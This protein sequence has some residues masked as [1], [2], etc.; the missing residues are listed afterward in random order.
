MKM[1]FCILFTFF[2]LSSFSQIQG[3]SEVS[4]RGD[5]IEP[6]FE[7]GLEGFQAIFYQMVKNKNVKI[8]E[9]VLDSVVIDKTGLMTKIK[10]IKFKDDDTAMSVLQ[11]LNEMNNLDIK[12]Q[13]A[14]R[15]GEVVPVKL[16]FP[17][18]F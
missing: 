15:L 3:E 14:R 5:L 18:K 1:F 11:T 9:T 8:G 7:G 12:W 2:S 13:P 16:E 6:E 17:F 10:I 4:L